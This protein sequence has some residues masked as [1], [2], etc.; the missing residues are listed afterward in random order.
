MGLRTKIGLAIAGTAALVSVVM[1]LLVHHRTVEAQYAGARSQIGD[2][3]QTAVQD[4]AAGV[5]GDRTLIDPVDLPGPLAGAVANGRWGVY[6][7][8]TGRIPQLWAATKYGKEVIALKRPYDREADTVRDLDRVLWISGGFGTALACVAGLLVATRLG[9]RLR[10]KAGA[11][12]RIAEG[13]LTARLPLRGN[14]E[15]TRLASAVNTM[16]D[17]LAAR[18]QAEREVTANIAHE[19]RTPVA[20]MVTAA[21]L[22]PPGR[23]SELVR[24]SAGRLRE[25]VDDVIEVARLDGAGEQV[26]AEECGLAALVRRSAAAGA[27]GA[28][29]VTVSVV[30]DVEVVT[31]PRRVERI[32]ANLVS[33]ALRHGAAPVTVEVDG[34]VVRVRDSGSG[35]PESL[36]SGGPQ[37]F[38]SGC[39]EK[40]VGLGLGLTIA[41]GQ[42]RVLGAGLRFGNPAEGGAEA[43][44]DMRSAA[45]EGSRAG[46]RS[47]S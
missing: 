22:L 23:P 19:L 38:R 8:R 27:A 31:D 32:V 24:E 28:D 26:A 16:A 42:A 47:F 14:D 39:G 43:V 6:L 5:D 44:L 25:L 3:L 12:Q 41:Q 34:G 33:N 20:G 11:A 18:L 7:D 1:G 35:F 10:A 2:R 40:G 17:A 15:I 30:R 36:L 37:R 4:H 13:D 29:G 45:K 46:Y 9:R 21:G